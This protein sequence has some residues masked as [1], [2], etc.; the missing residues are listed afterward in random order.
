[1]ITDGSDAIIFLQD[2]HL[3]LAAALVRA[4]LPQA[5]VQQFIHIP[6]PAIRYWEFLP[7]RFVLEIFEGLA[8]NDVVGFQSERDARNF[9]EC[10]RA[11]CTAAAPTWIRG[12]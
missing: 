10:A 11:F 3:Y 8:A 2:Y 7:E 1:V 12:A 9:L 4:R 5:V 6:W